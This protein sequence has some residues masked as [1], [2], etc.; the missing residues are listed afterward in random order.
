M[1]HGGIGLVHNTCSSPSQKTKLKSRS[2]LFAITPPICPKCGRVQPH[3]SHDVSPQEEQKLLSDRIEILN[4]RLASLQ[5][6]SFDLDRERSSLPI[7][8]NQPRLSASASDACSPSVIENLA[9]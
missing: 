1:G 2:P 6:Q 9:S 3:R 4:Q 7:R 8:P 5:S